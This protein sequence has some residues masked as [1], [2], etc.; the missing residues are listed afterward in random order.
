MNKKSHEFTQNLAKIG[1]VAKTIEWQAVEKSWYSSSN[2]AG[3]LKL[4]PL[5]SKYWAVNAAGWEKILA[6]IDTRQDKYIAE[7]YD[8]N[9]FAW[10]A[11]GEIDYQFG[12]NGCGFVIDY[13]GRHSYNI[14]LCVADDGS[15]EWRVCEPQADAWV[16]SEQL[17]RPPYNLATGT[18][19]L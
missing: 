13:S 1:V 15:I 6:E 2:P 14:A 10:R 3:R 5:D 4:V 11:K 8:C 16:A 12:L 17:D 19:L 18:V 7:R 9:H